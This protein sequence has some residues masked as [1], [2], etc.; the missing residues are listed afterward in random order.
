[1]NDFF[2]TKFAI[3]NGIS[4]LTQ[5]QE[6]IK[7]EIL[8]GRK[9]QFFSLP[10]RYGKTT[11]LLNIIYYF[12]FVKSIKNPIYF[13]SPWLSKENFKKECYEDFFKSYDEIFCG[14]R[15]FQIP[16]DNHFDSNL[17][18]IIIIDDASNMNTGELSNIMVSEQNFIKDSYIKKHFKYYMLIAI[19]CPKPTSDFN[20]IYH[21]NRSGCFNDYMLKFYNL[22]EI[23]DINADSDS[24]LKKEINN[25]E[26]YNSEIMGRF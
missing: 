2:R 24:F 17:P 11:A 21:L 5:Y 3:R 22:T 14:G 12:N 8:I 1:M 19:S 13:I 15:K 6:F 26:I 23:F 18:P 16:D 10:R 20:V 9:I 7:D 25:L 4:K